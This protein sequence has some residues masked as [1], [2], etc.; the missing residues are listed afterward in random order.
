M[1]GVFSLNIAYPCDDGEGWKS[2]SGQIRDDDHTITHCQ[3]YRQKGCRLSISLNIETFNYHEP[4]PTPEGSGTYGQSKS[5]GLS[6]QVGDAR[7]P[8][9]WCLIASRLATHS[10]EGASTT[11]E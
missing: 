5:I 9:A 4:D 3:G 7:L 10:E 11:I 2:K 6:T 1:L 8:A